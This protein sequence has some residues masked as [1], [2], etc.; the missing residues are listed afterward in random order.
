MFEAIHH[1]AYVVPDLD[2]ALELFRDT[3]GME[4]EK[5]WAS[6]EEGNRYAALKVGTSGAFLE[7]ICPTDASKSKFAAH[8]ME[9]G[10]SVHHVAFRD[11]SMDETLEVLN[12]HHGITGT[13]PIV[14]SSGWR[15]SFLD[16]GA[17]QDMGLQLVDGRHSNE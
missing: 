4:A 16:T 9:H 13:S 3:L 11:A 14:S 5:I 2:Q 1:V 7:L 8:L 10:A 12:R 6:E 15:I 17:T